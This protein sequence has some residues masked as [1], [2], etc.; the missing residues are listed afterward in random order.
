MTFWNI[1][2]PLR[3]SISATS[4]GVVT[5]TA[6]ER[7]IFCVSVSC[8]SPVPGRQ[9]DDEEVELAPGDVPEELLDRLHHHRP[10]P[11]DRLVDVHQEPERHDPDAVP[12]D[13]DDLV[14][15]VDEGLLVDAHHHLL[16]RAVDVGVH[17]AR[18]GGPARASASARFA[19]TVDLPDAPLA[20]GDRDLEPHLRQDARRR[21]AG[22]R[23]APR[24]GGGRGL[25]TSRR[26]VTACTPGSAPK[27]L[28]RVALDLLGR[29]RRRGRDLQPEGD[30][31]AADREVLDETE[32]DDVA[33]EARE[34]DGFQDLEDLLF[35]QLS[36]WRSSILRVR[37]L[38]H[39]APA[40]RR[41]AP[42]SR[43]RS[44][45]RHARRA[46]GVE[47]PATSIGSPDRED[48]AAGA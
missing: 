38:C 20:R 5:M 25:S 13:R 29:S 22:R 8:A 7:W 23:R 35:G 18:R 44:C 36:R 21:A 27:L 11:D 34:P 14:R 19:A 28:G 30:V 26:I 43:S 16:R 2:S 48:D 17:E 3:A 10:A 4:C 47:R 42:R 15:L 41:A 1:A 32:G 46:R 40:P 12:L 39:G 24:G 37:I 6:P 9:V 45:S 33:G 31:A